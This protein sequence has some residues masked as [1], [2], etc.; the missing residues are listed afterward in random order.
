MTD[1]S[2][3]E[4][5]NSDIDVVPDSSSN[6]ESLHGSDEDERER[7]PMFN[8]KDANNPKLR[9]RQTFT[10]FKELKEAIRT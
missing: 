4:I 5:D 1:D 8:P 2:D 7:H 3:S 6:L 9:F 10:N